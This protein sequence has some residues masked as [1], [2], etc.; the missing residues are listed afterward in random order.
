M[1][2]LF[3]RWDLQGRH[4]LGKVLLKKCEQTQTVIKRMT[5]TNTGCLQLLV[6]QVIEQKALHRAEHFAMDE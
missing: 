1:L 2:Y 5:P 6:G 3:K 4:D